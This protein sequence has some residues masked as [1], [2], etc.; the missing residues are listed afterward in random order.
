MVHLTLFTAWMI[1]ET[2]HK[3]LQYHKNSVTGSLKTNAKQKQDMPD[4]VY[5]PTNVNNYI[6]SWWELYWFLVGKGGKGQRQ[7]GEGTVTGLF[8]YTNPRDT[9][10]NA[11][12]VNSAP[13]RCATLWSWAHSF[14]IQTLNQHQKWLFGFWLPGMLEYQGCYG[15]IQTHLPWIN[16][17]GS[18]SIHASYLPLLP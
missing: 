13:W 8:Y 7:S 10:G 6:T 2:L 12:Y 3:V 14:K 15:Q 4:I 11:V 16:D 17:R 18:S 9:T 5:I 1:N